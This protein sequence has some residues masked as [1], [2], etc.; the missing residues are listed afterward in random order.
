M[1]MDKLIVS[2]NIEHAQCTKYIFKGLNDVLPPNF[3]Y[4]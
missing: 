3:Y 2:L 4:F 1:L